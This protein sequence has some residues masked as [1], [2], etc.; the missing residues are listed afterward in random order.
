M[1]TFLVVSIIFSVLTMLAC[2]ND[3][4]EPTGVIDTAPACPTGTADYVGC[5]DTPGCQS[6]AASMPDVPQRWVVDRIYLNTANK[7]TIYRQA[8]DDSSCSGKLAFASLGSA[9]KFS[10][11]GPTLGGSGV[12]EYQLQV[13]SNTPNSTQPSYK[14]FLAV[15]ASNTLCLSNNWDVNDEGFSFKFNDGTG[16]DLTNCLDPVH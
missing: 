5:W 15:T 6:I 12:M 10:V 8:Y 7:F 9:H 3:S 2:S 11:T 13:D 14:V 1:K 4:T 16:V